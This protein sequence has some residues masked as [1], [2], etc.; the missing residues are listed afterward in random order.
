MT[1]V[2]PS[3]VIGGQ[4]VPTD[5]FTVTG[6][7][8]GSTGSLSSTTSIAALE[9][10]GL[11]IVAL[12]IAD[13]GSLPVDLYVSGGQFEQMHW[14]SGEYVTGDFDYNADQVTV[15][16]RDWSGPLVDEK[17]ALTSL[18]GGGGALAPEEKES[19]I[20]TQNQKLSQIVTQIAEQFSLTPDLRLNSKVSNADANYGTV[21][22]D[23]TDTILT[24]V[25]RSLWGVLNQLARHS[26][27]IVYVTP[28]K[29][30]VFG[31]AGAGLDTLDFSWRQNGPDKLPLLRL[32]ITHNPRRNMTFRVLVKSYDPTTQQLTN[33]QA[34][35]IGSDYSTDGGSTVH[36]GSWGS[37]QSA[38]IASA[39]GTGKGSKK[40]AI[41]VYTYHVD[42]LTAAQAQTR[43]ESI[44]SD[45]AKRELVA[46][47]AA[48]A[49]PD[50][51]PG[52]PATLAGLINDEFAAH[53]YYVTAFNHRFHVGSSGA[54]GELLTDFVMLDRQPEGS[55]KPVS[56]PAPVG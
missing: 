13:P 1:A 37:A 26:G 25:P 54:G 22:G 35:V 41:P 51:A 27:N 32:R 52:Q 36:A 33:G 14:F 5:T 15:H 44:A 55:G 20:S 23:S 8:Y 53:T 45:I 9:E 6:G 3:L 19:G 49:I 7:A 46:H 43:A 28:E 29:H 30:L 24:T 12:S 40:N 16:A 11:D 48:D 47:C 4:E 56:K 17:R 10:A 39:V 50:M 34:Y 18:L 31:E 42:G 21:F 2:I 38:S